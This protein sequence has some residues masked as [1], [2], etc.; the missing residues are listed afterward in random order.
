MSIKKANNENLNEILSSPKLN[1][2]KFSAEWCG[3]CKMLAPVYHEIA[4]EISDVNFY[5]VDIDD[6]S[7]ETLVNKYSV[8][9]VPTVIFIK[10]GEKIHDFAGFT[11]K[12]VFVN[13]INE[14]K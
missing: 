1:V 10:N 8:N 12:E 9:V 2:I 5:E 4:N 14:K 3:P 7:A 13:L 11:P 6:E